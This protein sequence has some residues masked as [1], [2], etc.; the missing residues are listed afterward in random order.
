MANDY[1]KYI[2]PVGG[3]LLF[4]GFGT[5]ILEKF[6]VVKGE[7]A[8][9]NEAKANQ[10]GQSALRAGWKEALKASMAGRKFTVMKFSDAKAKDLATRIYNAKRYV[11]DIE[12]NVFSALRACQYQSIVNQVADTFFAK[13]K[14]DLYSYLETFF[15][16]SEMAKCYDIVQAL[17]LG[18]KSK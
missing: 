8:K 15:N 13:Y 2:I 7:E 17:P 3:L 11:N 4:F 6:G 1:S 9:A 12:E 18:I 5:K 16:A 14:I 10:L